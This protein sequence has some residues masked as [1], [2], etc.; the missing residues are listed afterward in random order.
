MSSEHLHA[1]EKC[2]LVLK[3]LVNK[4]T[5]KTW[6]MPINP[7]NLQ[8]DTLTI[9]VPNKF[10]YE[11]I[12]EN[13]IKELHKAIYTVIGKEGKLSY[14]L[15]M[16]DY[17]SGK[18]KQKN[19]LPIDKMPDIQNPFVIPGIKRVKFVPQLNQDYQMYNLIEGDC[20]SLAKSA[21]GAVAENPGKTAFNPLFIYGDVG[22][23]KTHLI[24]AIGNEV[25][26]LHP[27]KN[28]LY[29]TTEK[30]TNQFIQAIRNGSTNDFVNFYQMVDVLIVDDIQFLS[31]KKKTQEIFF[32]IF[33][34]LKQNGK[35]LILTAD[36]SPSE[37][38]GIMDRLISR[39]KWGLEADL[40]QPDY[41]TRIAIMQAKM[42]NEGIKVPDEVC[43]LVCYHVKNNIRELE[44]VLIQLIAQ[45]TF[46]RRE[47]DINLAKEVIRRF[48]STDNKEVTVELIKE[49]VS[50]HFGV[51]LEKLGSKSRK[52]DI[53]IARHVS[54]YLSKQYTEKSLKMIGSYFGGRDHSTILHSC[55]TVQD[56]IDTDLAFK[57]TISNLERQMQIKSR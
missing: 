15:K 35:Q 46:G 54:I 13:L 27:N 11:Y 14:Q 20:N 28:V 8:D 55:K 47:I 6:F 30:F 23:G 26:K 51:P 31:E 43:E 16:K 33:N 41:E 3:D 40:H 42:E 29:V 24:Q 21:G 45:A 36:R 34:H 4:E 2:L 22:L 56:R 52:Q 10:F 37:I 19:D 39:F 5:F 57:D 50:E 9:E 1:W 18:A 48:N 25:V 53:A 12:E 17:R 32:N 7:V 49:M 38:S 44:G